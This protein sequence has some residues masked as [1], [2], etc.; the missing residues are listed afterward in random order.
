[1]KKVDQEVGHLVVQVLGAG[2]EVK[3]AH[4]FIFTAPF[5]HIAHHGGIDA[6]RAGEHYL[7]G[8]LNDEDASY[9]GA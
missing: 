8:V 7:H 4:R 2:P 6:L 1:M 9:Q 5:L 3:D